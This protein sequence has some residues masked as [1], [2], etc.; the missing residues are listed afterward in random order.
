ME[1]PIPPIKLSH[2]LMPRETRSAWLGGGGVEWQRRYGWWRLKKGEERRIVEARGN[3][4]EE[5]KG[6][7]GEGGREKGLSR[8]L[9]IRRH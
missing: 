2:F 6:R 4:S 8:L 1:H 3:W 7:G 9:K 5:G